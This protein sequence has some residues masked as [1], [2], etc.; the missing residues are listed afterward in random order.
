M[1]ENEA[2]L[3]VPAASPESPP[4]TSSGHRHFSSA[5]LSLFG[6]PLLSGARRRE[7]T[8]AALELGHAG[9]KR[10]GPVDL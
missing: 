4:A 2:N 3:M 10:V 6:G 5:S 1:R 7:P 8:R 9:A